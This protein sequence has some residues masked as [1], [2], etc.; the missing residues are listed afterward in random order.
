MQNKE[1]AESC[2]NREGLK[3]SGWAVARGIVGDDWY[4]SRDGWTH[5]LK[6]SDRGD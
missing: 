6:G 1:K 4:Q 3:I 5:H 2:V